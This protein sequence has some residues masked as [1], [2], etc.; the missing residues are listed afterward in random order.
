MARVTRRS[1]YHHHRRVE[2]HHAVGRVPWLRAAV[3]GAN[4]GIVSTASIVL[5]V[6]ASSASR[7]AVL[8]AG[9]AG[10]AAGAMSMAAG[11]FVSVSS[12][13][14]AEKADLRREA[15]ELERFPEAELAELAG[16]YE[17][18]GLSPDLA[19]TVAEELSEGDRLAVHARD[20]LG[21]TELGTA[22]PVQAAVTS[23]LAF[24]A[25][26]AVPVL[27]GIV[28]GGIGIV[29]VIVLSL[30]AL[31]VLGA[32]AA[33]LGGAPRQ[34]AALRV[35]GGGATAMAATSAIGALVGATGL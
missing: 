10:W 13:R 18:R 29:L 21:L 16:I 6:A 14:D 35:L 33:A 31:A 5:G 12:Q 27:A 23:A 2:D 24:S 7:G 34:R 20:E 22:R 11:E 28:P 25:G 17:D 9:I 26:A 15:W 32:T 1:R 19:R 4:D 30:V 8:T 3:L